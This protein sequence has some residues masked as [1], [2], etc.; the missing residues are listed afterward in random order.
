VARDRG[1]KGNGPP[2]FD[3][4]GKLEILS[5]GWIRW[6]DRDPSW[7]DVFGFRGRN[8]VESP[9]DKWSRVE[10]VCK[11]DRITVFVNGKRVNEV[12]NVFPSS[13]KILLQCEGS[14]VFF[15]KVVLH[16]LQPEPGINQ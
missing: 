8:D 1:S 3:P 7:R 11:G 13:G 12:Q 15:R 4:S 14:E 5:K 6:S 2:R 9:A 10:C 16:P